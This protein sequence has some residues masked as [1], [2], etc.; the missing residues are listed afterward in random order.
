MIQRKCA[1]PIN[2]RDDKPNR[3]IIVFTAFSDTAHYLYAQLA[4][5]ARDALGMHAAVVTGSAGLQTTLPNL[6]TNMGDVLSAFAPGSKHRPHDPPDRKTR[7]WVKSVSERVN[8][9]RARLQQ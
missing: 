4:P 5:W 3:K 6:R 8:P 1:E 2:T 7:V 9:G